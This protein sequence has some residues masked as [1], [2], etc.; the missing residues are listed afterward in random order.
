MPKSLSRS[1]TEGAIIGGTWG[2]LATTFTFLST[3]PIFFGNALLIT[4]DAESLSGGEHGEAAGNYYADSLTP[5]E[6]YEN[7]K[8]IVAC[9]A[10]TGAMVGMGFALARKGMFAIEHVEE[11]GQRE[12]QTAPH[13]N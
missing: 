8:D 9:G 10:I 7:G 6:L 4:L 12:P 2:A 13:L 11:R 3:A 1:L 5:A